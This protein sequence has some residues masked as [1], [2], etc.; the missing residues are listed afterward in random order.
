MASRLPTILFPRLRPRRRNSAAARSGLGQPAPGA[1]TLLEVVAAIAII[2]V[3][4]LVLIPNLR[5]DTFFFIEPKQKTRDISGVI[6]MPAGAF[7]AAGGFDEAFQKYGHEDLELRLRLWRKLGL[8]FRTFPGEFMSTVIRSI[9]H[10]DAMRVQHYREK[11]IQKNLADTLSQMGQAYSRY[12]PRQ[13]H[14]DYNGQ[15]GP[16]VKFLMGADAS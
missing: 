12:S 13:L 5:P 14:Q 15:D 2:V 6:A 10:T 3:L 7:T 11:D 1:F 16:I 8:G 9:P 4:A